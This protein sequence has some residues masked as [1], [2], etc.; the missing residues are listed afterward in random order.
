M[1]QITYK[2]NGEV[3]MD[4]Y[5]FR[6]LPIHKIMDT[7]RDSAKVRRFKIRTVT[8]SVSEFA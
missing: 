3:R 8:G 4:Y 1:K 2:N 5:T 7:I 6:K